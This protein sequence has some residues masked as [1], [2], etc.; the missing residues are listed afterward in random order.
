VA[1]FDGDLGFRFR[2][3]SREEVQISRNGKVVTTL[4]GSDA[5]DFLADAEGA[6]DNDQQQ[7]MARVTGNYKRGNER[8]AA[9]HPRNR[10]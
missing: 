8:T 10:K 1:E 5:I 9:N 3:K 2:Q 7:I 4:R 6:D